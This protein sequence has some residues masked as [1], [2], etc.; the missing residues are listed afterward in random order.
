MCAAN[1]LTWHLCRASGC[2]MRCDTEG[3][4]MAH[5]RQIGP[6]RALQVILL[7]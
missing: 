4:D 6:H 7:G 1:L 3:Q 2:A 5:M